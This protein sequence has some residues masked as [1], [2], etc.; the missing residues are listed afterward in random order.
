M[1]FVRRFLVALALIAAARVEAQAPATT[2]QPALTIAVQNR[3]AAQDAAR[4]TAR[5]DSTVRPG[6]LLHYTLTF[7]N[8]TERALRN[9]QLM[10]PLPKGIELVA[11]TVKA[12][13]PDAQAEFSADGGKTFSATPTIAVVVDGKTERRPVPPAQYTHVRWTVNGAV[14]P[15][16]TVTAEYDTR[17]STGSREVR[18]ATPSSPGSG[19]R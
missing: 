8:S 6:D 17:V 5:R 4:G 16:A 9:V 19:S 18:G 14:A 13:R 1:S 10:N 3:T 15:Q 2:P 7:V 11:G 12:S